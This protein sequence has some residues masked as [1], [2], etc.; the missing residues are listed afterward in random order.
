MPSVR[1]Y[2]LHSQSPLAALPLLAQRGLDKGHK[3]FIRAKD[4]GAAAAIDSALWDFLPQSFL[5]HAIAGGPYDELQPVLIGTDF[6]PREELGGMADMMIVMPD[7][8][9]ETPLDFPPCVTLAC[10][11]LDGADH[12]HIALSRKR[13]AAYKE[14]GYELSYWQQTGDGKWE[15]KA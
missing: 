11:I 8:A 6:D 2:H 4:D 5:P 3:I 1:F 7:A 12:A 10:E 15:Q 9:G 14:A 13:W